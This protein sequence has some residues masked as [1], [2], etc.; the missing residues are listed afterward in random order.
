MFQT[1]TTNGI[2]TVEAIPNG[3]SNGAF[4]VAGNSSSDPANN[5]IASIGIPA[6]NIDVRIQST[7][8]G[9]GTYLPMTFYTGGSERMRLDTSGNV[10]IGTS[11]GSARLNVNG[12][13]ST[14]QI[15]W[16]VN[17]AA[18]TQEVSTN[19]AA[20]A[21]VYKSNDASYHVWK[22]SSSEAMRID[23]SGNV[24]IGTTSPQSSLQV[25]GTLGSAP[26]GAGVHMGI[27]STFA[28]IQLN[29]D[30]STGSLID[31]STSGTDYLGR[32]LY[33]NASNFLSFSTNNSEKMRINS[34][35]LVGIGT[36]SPQGI[37]DVVGSGTQAA[38]NYIYLQGGN[39]GGVNPNHGGGFAFA[40]N[41]S[42]GNSE[43]NM[44]WSGSAAGQYFSISRWNGTAVTE[45]MRI[46]SSGNVGIGTSSPSQK[47]QVGDGTADTRASFRANN[48]FAVG[49]ANG[50]G[51]AGWIGGSGT[52]DVM[53]F[54][55]SG[56]TERMRIDSSGNVLVTSAA[57]LG[58]GTGSGGTVTQATDKSTAVT[59]NK[60]TGKITMNNAAM[61]T[62]AIVQFQFTNSLLTTSDVLQIT[63]QSGNGSTGNYNVWVYGQNSGNA[64][65]AVKNIS[66]F[67]LSDALVLNFAIIKGATS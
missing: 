67:T 58:Y 43:S 49:I 24:G 37:L 66:A 18:F 39:V 16:E 48:A 4:F 23:S 64:F 57:G 21:Y 33:N 41:F 55:N 3:T 29:G 47:L 15:R 34:N 53:V 26:T 2:T 25:S 38:R 52:T 51:F 10:G 44:I 46:D 59:L 63:Q 54:S 40:I 61:L 5:S 8:R 6:A 20:N 22:L 36:T 12:G 32:I 45:Q 9:T 11:S 31:F 50:S 17:N 7:I 62:N 28:S 30:A 42:G 27:T 13:T 56:G 35:G 1:S 14:S 65:I 19:A 60:P